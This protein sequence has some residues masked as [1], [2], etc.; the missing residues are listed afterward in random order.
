VS[1][2]RTH[3]RAEDSGWRDGFKYGI[4]GTECKDCKE[5]VKPGSC[6][7]VKEVI[8]DDL[9]LYQFDVNRLCPL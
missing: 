3:S 6:L 9:L 2:N 8:F 1:R 5:D 4:T 7:A